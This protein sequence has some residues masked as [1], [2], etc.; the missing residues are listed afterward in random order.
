MLGL[1]AVERNPAARLQKVHSRT[2]RETRYTGIEK[3]E[4]LE[5]VVEEEK[6]SSRRRIYTKPDVEK[7]ETVFSVRP[8]SPRFFLVSRSCFVDALN[9]L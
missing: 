1:N 4:K 2:V 8:C 3:D 9:S 6:S 7:S 5:T